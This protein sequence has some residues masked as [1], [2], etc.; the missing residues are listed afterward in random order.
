MANIINSNLII[1][2]KANKEFVILKIQC[3]SMDIELNLCVRPYDEIH[4]ISNG[5]FSA[6]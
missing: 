4:W 3:Y 6:G 2:H 1:V 5:S